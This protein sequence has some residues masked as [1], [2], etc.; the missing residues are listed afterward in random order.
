[1]NRK[2]FSVAALLIAAV[3]LLN[4]SSC[5]RSQKLVGITVTPSGSTIT[6]SGFGQVVGTQFTALGSYIHPPET[7]GHYEQGSVDHGHAHDY[8]YGPEYART[9]EHHR[10]RLRNQSWRDRQS[11]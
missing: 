9:G 4:L 7:K 5:A 8:R 1:M 11:L 2:W 3:A 6:L 10:R